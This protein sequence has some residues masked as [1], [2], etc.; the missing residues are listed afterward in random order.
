MRVVTFARVWTLRPTA[1][2]PKKAAASGLNIQVNH[3]L[4]SRTH[5]TITIT[6]SYEATQ[7]HSHIRLRTT[8]ADISFNTEPTFANEV[9]YFQRINHS[10]MVRNKQRENPNLHNAE[11]P[12]KFDQLLWC[13]GSDKRRGHIIQRRQGTIHK[14]NLCVYDNAKL[15]NEDRW[16][17]LYTHGRRKSKVRCTTDWCWKS[18]TLGGLYE[19]RWQA[20][21]C[22]PSLE[23]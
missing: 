21:L 18:N 14:P 19:D 20:A 22:L 3:R 11:Q 7:I 5:T 15:D 16:Q 12:I 8:T 23:I 6:W 1:E 9:S 4:P 10:Q 13:T 2:S 17:L